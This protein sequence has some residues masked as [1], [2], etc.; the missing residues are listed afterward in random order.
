M[1]SHLQVVITHAFTPA[2]VL[3]DKL[4]GYFWQAASPKA[5]AAM[6]RWV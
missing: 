4:R 2:L 3:L 1:L 6:L 5:Q